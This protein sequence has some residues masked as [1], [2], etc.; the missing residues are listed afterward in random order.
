M[1]GHLP[2]NI[3]TPKGALMARSQ[4]HKR[5]SAKSARLETRITAEQKALFER[6]AALSGRS[7]TDFVIGSTYEAAQRTL[8]EH[9]RMILAGDDRKAFVQA[10]LKPAAPGPRLRKAVKRYKRATGL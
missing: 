8:R 1:Y 9:E 4:A 2:Y 7:L 3:A 5:T 6:A 10:L